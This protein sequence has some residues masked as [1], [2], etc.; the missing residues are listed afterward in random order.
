MGVLRARTA[1]G[2]PWVDVNQGVVNVSYGNALGIVQMGSFLA[3]LVPHSV[4]A[5]TNNPITNP[6]TRTMAVGRRYRLHLQIRAINPSAPNNIVSFYLRDNGTPNRSTTYGG[7]P[8]VWMDGPFQSAVFSWLFDGDGASHALEVIANSGV[9][10]DLYT[11]YGLYYLE[12]VGPNTSPALPI[13]ETPPTWTPVPLGA[14]WT[15]W[16]APWGPCGYRKI[17]DVVTLRGLAVSTSTVTTIATLPVGFR[18]AVSYI[19]PTIGQDAFSEIRVNLDGTIVVAYG[20][21]IT[22]TSWVSLNNVF[23][24]TTA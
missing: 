2:A 1:V 16:A 10:F 20:P 19:G 11:D 14:T 9:G 24:S 8:Y 23:F 4:A 3:P 7:D 15:H 12:D 18:P 6:L 17:G 13:P 21:A 22:N 5:N